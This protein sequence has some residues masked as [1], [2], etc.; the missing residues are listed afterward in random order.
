MTVRTATAIRRTARLPRTGVLDRGAETGDHR[1]RRPF[2]DGGQG[3]VAHV[4]PHGVVADDPVQSRSEAS[5]I[6][7][8]DDEAVDAVLD[9]PTRSR[10]DS[11]GGDHGNA[12][13]E[14]LV[15]D[16]PP[17]LLPLRRRDRG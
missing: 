5:R 17:E 7:F 11:I 14:R 1:L 2:I 4:P 6:T 9:Q 13:V 16:E 3:V 15:D 8:G 12:L 10:A